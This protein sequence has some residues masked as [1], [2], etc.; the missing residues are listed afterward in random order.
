MT[1]PPVGDH[2]EISTGYQQWAP[3]YDADTADRP[4]NRYGRLFH[5]LARRYANI[6]C[7]VGVRL[8]DLGC[9]SGISSLGFAALGYAVL[10]CDLSSAMLDHARAKPH[11]DQ[12]RFEEADLR[13][14][15]D[16]GEFDVICAVTNPMDHLLTDEDFA[17]A[18]RGI[19]R[20]LA[21]DGVFLF[22]QLSERAHHRSVRHP[23]VRES[24]GQFLICRT[25]QHTLP[26]EPEPVFTRRMDRFVRHA[27]GQ[28]HRIA[29]QNTF[30]ARSETSVRRLLTRAQL[31]CVAVHPVSRLRQGGQHERPDERVLFVARHQSRQ[32]RHS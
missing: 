16:W 15:P 5:D 28:W 18:L 27:P 17:S 2:D 13:H 12:V 32:V 25:W 11:A 3:F 29:H 30:R 31:D 14:L 24:D 6:P 23:A 4:F 1:A 19:V 22:D 10:G 7:P 26:T 8:L 20:S 21:P 9:G